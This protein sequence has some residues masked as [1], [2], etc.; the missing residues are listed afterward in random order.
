VGRWRLTAPLG[1]GAMGT[2]WRAHHALDGSPAAIKLLVGVGAEEAWSRAAFAWEIRACGALSHPGVVALLDH[3][4]L[5][6]R[7]TAA[8]GGRWQA[9]S[10]FLAMELVEGRPLHDA[11]GRLPWPLLREVLGQ[12]LRALAHCHAR[13][14]IHRDLK[15]GNVL[16]TGLGGLGVQRGGDLRVQLTDFGLAAPP[17]VRPELE[18]TVAGTPA[19]MPP[20]QLRGDWRKM[21]PSSDL[22]ATGCLAWALCTGA[23]P[24]G[25]R[26]PLHELVAEHSHRPPPPLEPMMAVPA[27]FEAW[28]RRLLEKDPL[29]RYRSAPDALDALLRLSEHEPWLDAPV[30]PVKGEDDIDL[31]MEGFSEELPD[32]MHEASTGARGLGGPKEDSTRDVPGTGEVG[33]VWEPVSRP[34]APLSR[35]AVPENWRVRE[36]VAVPRPTDPRLFGLRRAPLFGREEV[37]DA[38]WAA[39]RQVE[40]GGGVRAVVLEG[41]VGCGKGRIAS[42]LLE[43]AAE[44]GGVPGVRVR[45]RDGERATLVAALMERG[46]LP[47]PN[48]SSEML[49]RAIGELR[50]PKGRGPVLVWLDEPVGALEPPNFWTG[51]LDQSC[52]GVGMGELGNGARGGEEGALPPILLL[53]SRPDP[54]T[55]EEDLLDELAFH[56]RSER[57]RVGPLSRGE[58]LVLT[59]ALLGPG[60]SEE[61]CAALA[62]RTA[63]NPLFAV[64]LV[65]EWF[66]QGLLVPIEGGWRLRPGARLDLPDGLHAV[67]SARVERLLAEVGEGRPAMAEAQRQV[68]EVAALAPEPVEVGAWMACCGRLRLRPHANLVRILEKER[69][70]EL[71]EENYRF[72]QPLLRA[73]LARGAEDAGRAQRVHRAWASVVELRGAPDRDERISRH[74]LAAGD[75][76]DALPYLL[77]AAERYLARGD[78]GEARALLGRWTEVCTR[79]GLSARDPQQAR[80][81]LLRV[82][83]LRSQGQLEEALREGEATLARC[84]QEGWRLAQGEVLLELGVVLRREGR[85]VK[86][87]ARLAEASLVADELQDPRFRAQVALEGVRGQVERGQVGAARDALA[88]L[89]SQPDLL[90]LAEQADV[91]R[92]SALVERM[93]G[94]IGAATVRVEEARELAMRSGSRLTQAAVHNEMGELARAR[95]EMGEAEASY[96][97]AEG[98]LDGI[99]ADEQRLVRINLAILLLEQRRY[100]EARPL[101]GEALARAASAGQRGLMAVLQVLLL[102][103]AAADGAWREW[104]ERLLVAGGLLDETGLVD[105]DL[106][107]A[108]E[109]AAR[110]ARDAGQAAR[111]ERVVALSARLSALMR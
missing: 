99:G 97:L 88:R 8:T 66:A 4:S 107:R 65:G 15:P 17:G 35:C 18:R 63:G 34:V 44:L 13:G 53:V 59:R 7:V 45:A 67:W 36:G 73:S 61:L 94:D 87:A 57:L 75:A 83:L 47:D 12:L 110:L 81:A 95:G 26:R 91:A 100:R 92:L 51:L 1:R 64:E 21:G 19:Y 33:G 54:A 24:F 86:A 48:A 38:L 39:L 9:G 41:P 5:D 70:V 102:A 23:P 109:R 84:A 90:S 108:L 105:P 27:G 62:E 98:I 96:R 71:R 46:V 32:G 2:V 56:P 22:Y 42:W 43:Q 72:T 106:F 20:E 28:L 14:W 80:A 10:P 74:L 31:F 49:V 3:G 111:S 89:G 25:R 52:A 93:R 103:C 37:R 11:V 58:Q 77:G 50:G 68:L 85:L 6:E 82:R 79:E 55:E 78:T 101:L 104:D 30:P 40:V 76:R 69:L 60:S 29:D 16:V